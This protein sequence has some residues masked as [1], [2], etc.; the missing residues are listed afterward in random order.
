MAPVPSVVSELVSQL[1]IQGE[2]PVCNCGTLS[3]G[4]EGGWE[5]TGVVWKNRRE[6]RQ[7][8]RRWRGVG[9]ERKLRLCSFLKIT[10]LPPPPCTFPP[11]S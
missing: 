11:L 10:L 6:E 9:V 4:G 7:G 5:E 2:K 8:M 1:G 3:N